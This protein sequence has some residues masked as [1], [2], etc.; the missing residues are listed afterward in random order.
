MLRLSDF[1]MND[2]WSIKILISDF[3]VAGIDCFKNYS[4]SQNSGNDKPWAIS[5]IWLLSIW[6]HM[7]RK[8]EKEIQ[9]NGKRK[10]IFYEK[11][12]NYHPILQYVVLYNIFFVDDAIIAS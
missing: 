4:F 8:R 5:P 9:V 10:P 7:M 11:T 1:L 3:Y 12:K 2:V 6:S